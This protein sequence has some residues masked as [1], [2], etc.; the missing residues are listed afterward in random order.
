MNRRRI[1]VAL[2]GLGIGLVFYLGYRSGSTVSNRLLHR[3]CGG[4][5]Y[6]QL[7]YTARAWLPVPGILRGCLPSALWCLIGTSL[8]GGWKINVRGRLLP[9]AWLCPSFNA[10]WEGVQKLGW[11]DGR[12][13]PLDVLAGVAGWAVAQ[14]IFRRSDAAAVL[15]FSWNWRMSVVVATIACVGLADVWK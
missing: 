2:A 11:T 10:A 5:T 1:A 6:E 15:P 12:A 3:L 4:E 8:L 13:D 14:A 9:L 7:K